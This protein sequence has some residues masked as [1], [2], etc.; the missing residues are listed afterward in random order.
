VSSLN[1]NIDDFKQYGRRNSLRFHN[2]PA[3]S[4]QVSDTD[5]VIINLCKEK[6]N[7]EIS[8]NYINRSHILGCVNREGKVL[9]I[10]RFRNWKIK[11]KIYRTKTKLKGNT[12]KSFITEDLTIYRRS[13]VARPSNYHKESKIA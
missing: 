6:L 2:V 3:S 10:S 4:E 5:S 8:E 11:N 12:N 13:L 9:I 7:V 1:K